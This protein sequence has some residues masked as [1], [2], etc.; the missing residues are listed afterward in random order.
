M[1]RFSKDQ[2]TLDTQ[3][4]MT[5]YSVRSVVLTLVRANGFLPAPG[6]GFQC[7]RHCGF[8]ILHGTLLRHHLRAALRRILCGCGVLSAKFR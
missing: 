1:S 7:H 2:D 4:Q 8:S 5:Y 6:Y 3:L